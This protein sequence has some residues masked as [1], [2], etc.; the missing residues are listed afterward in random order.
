[1]VWESTLWVPL[2]STATTHCYRPSILCF[3]VEL[4]SG[5]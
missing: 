1:M 5:D 2:R 4:F 3:L